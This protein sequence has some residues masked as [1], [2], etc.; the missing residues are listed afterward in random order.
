MLAISVTNGTKY[1]CNLSQNG[2]NM[3]AMT[4]IVLESRGY[5]IWM[6]LTKTNFR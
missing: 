3:L 5:D 1:A 6:N 4:K 2:L